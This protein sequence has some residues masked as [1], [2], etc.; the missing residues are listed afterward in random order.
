MTYYHFSLL[1][2]ALTATFD[3]LHQGASV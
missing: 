2:I 3:E 1:Q